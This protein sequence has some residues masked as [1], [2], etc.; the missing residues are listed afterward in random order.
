MLFGIRAKEHFGGI[1]RMTAAV[2]AF[3]RFANQSTNGESCAR[4]DI[5]L[6]CFSTPADDRAI[7]RVW[8]RCR[9]RGLGGDGVGRLLH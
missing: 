2:S 6:G 3:T 7:G 8:P 5:T 4:E 1:H 9:R